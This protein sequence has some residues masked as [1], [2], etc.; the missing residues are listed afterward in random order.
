MYNIDKKIKNTF[1]VTSFDT[2]SNLD[3]R[4]RIIL[5][6]DGEKGLKNAFTKA[7]MLLHDEFHQGELWV[8]LHTW[9]DLEYIKKVLKKIWKYL[10]FISEGKDSHVLYFFLEK[11]DKEAINPLLKSHIENDFSKENSINSV[12]FF[13]SFLNGRLINVYDDRGADIVFKNEN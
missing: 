3:N 13:V 9:N 11:Y 7:A 6:S 5:N 2:L 10:I 1:G 4:T 8:R 12:C